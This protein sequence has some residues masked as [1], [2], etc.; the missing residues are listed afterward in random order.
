MFRLLFLCFLEFPYMSSSFGGG[1]RRPRISVST[2][3]SRVQNT[4]L[5]PSSR[6]N[7]GWEL[8]ERIKG[9][10]CDRDTAGTG[11]QGEE[12][13]VRGFH[14]HRFPGSVGRGPAV[15]RQP[16][17]PNCILQQRH[18]RPR[19]SAPAKPERLAFPRLGDGA[20]LVHHARETRAGGGFPVVALERQTAGVAG[21]VDAREPTTAEG[22]RLRSQPVRLVGVDNLLVC[23]LRNFATGNKSG[24]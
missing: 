19:P 2:G 5:S 10:L 23:S 22:E 15:G 1:V 16:T 14:I 18:Q 12:S 21:G 13:I 4:A 11:E 8:L 17:R 20:G 6:P 24:E 9:A 7:W 3:P